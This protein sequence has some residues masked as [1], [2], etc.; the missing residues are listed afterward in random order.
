MLSLIHGQNVYSKVAP[1]GDLYF[2]HIEN[3]D[4]VAIRDVL[5]QNEICDETSS[6]SN[7]DEQENHNMCDAIASARA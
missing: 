6:C 5:G 4:L 2:P 7:R 3:L 1:H